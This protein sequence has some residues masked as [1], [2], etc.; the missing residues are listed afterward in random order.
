VPGQS[1]NPNGRPKGA[2]NKVLLAIEGLIEGHS[3]EVVA[4]AMEKALDGDTRMLNAMLNR[5][6]PVRRERPV[7][8]DLPKIESPADVVKAS[9]AVLAACAAGELSPTEAST[10]HGMISTHMRVV[11]A[12]GFEERFAAVEKNFP[13]LRTS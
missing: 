7:E 9:A 1:G 4:K 13:I 10:F 5:V 11:E 2:R 12:A 8:L 3:E 6:A